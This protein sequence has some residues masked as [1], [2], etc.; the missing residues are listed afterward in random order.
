MGGQLGGQAK[1]PN[2]AELF[3]TDKSA[4][5]VMADE[6][7]SV[8]IVGA[9]AIGCHIAY[10]LQSAGCDVTLIAR[11]ENLRA[12]Q[13]EGLQIC[14]QGS[15]TEKMR[16]RAT[17]KPT[18]VGRVDYVFL[19]MKVFAYDSSILKFIAPLID[20]RTVI[21]PPTTA[22]P[23]WFLH[24]MKGPLENRRL[25]NVDPDGSIWDGLPPEQVLGFTM[26]LSAVQEAP[27]KVVLRHVQR[28]YPL[29]EIDG[30]HSVRLERLA[31]AFERGGVPAPRAA[32][33][34]SEIFVKSLN[35]L[36]FNVVALLG[37]ASNGVIA[38]V[39]EAVEVLRSVMRECEVLARKLGLEIRQ[40][41]D[42]R[43][44]QTL[45]ARMHTMSNLHDFRL[46][47]KLE[48]G[49]IWNSMQNLAELLEV[50]LPVT[51]ALVAMATLK[52]AA[53]GCD[54]PAVSKDVS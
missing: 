33:I 45:A 21:L 14:F 43:I 37:D 15:G 20:K 16:I 8:C 11:G 42:S 26:W 1:R 35:S 30:S 13:E 4:C 47:K 44:Q 52:A 32:C 53:R 48:L 5:P 40:D 22:I 51:R 49:E 54:N 34:R 36:A 24:Q 50:Q 31:M 2:L 12:L 29:G 7:F 27:G 19:T 3:V 23:Y 46:G 6:T 17:D 28:G 10:V 25:E 9:G 18:E 39:P 41:A 38:E